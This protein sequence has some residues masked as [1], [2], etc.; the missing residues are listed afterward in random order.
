MQLISPCQCPN[1]VVGS[2]STPR[3]K[4]AR[5]FDFSNMTPQEMEEARRTLSVKG[6]ISFH[7]S[8][9]LA[10]MDGYVLHATV[11]TSPMA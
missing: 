1:S 3:G 7:Q 11:P 9:T 8:G 10:L 2:T 6:K 5:S 4:A